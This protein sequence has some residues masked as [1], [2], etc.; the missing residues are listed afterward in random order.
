MGLRVKVREG[1]MIW[2]NEELKTKANE[3]QTLTVITMN[4]LSKQKIRTY[5]K[6]N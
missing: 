1:Q 5:P 3:Q 6:I 4:T 2:G